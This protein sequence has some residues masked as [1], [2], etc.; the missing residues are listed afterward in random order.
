MRAIN[1]HNVSDKRIIG[2]LIID[3]TGKILYVNP[4]AQNLAIDKT[5]I[6]VGTVLNNAPENR[7]YP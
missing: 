1:D 5:D 2:F 6:A 3:Q 4:G 7:Q